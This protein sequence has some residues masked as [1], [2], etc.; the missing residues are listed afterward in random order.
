MLL[1]KIVFRIS[2]RKWNSEDR[3]KK[4][5]YHCDREI[6]KMKRVE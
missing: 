4:Q 6:V 2:L 1:D 3:I 5:K